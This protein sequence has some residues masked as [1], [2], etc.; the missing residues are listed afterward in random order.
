MGLACVAAI[1]LH[2]LSQSGSSRSAED[3]RAGRAGAV[4]QLH[5]PVPLV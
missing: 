3:A 2:Q 1:F 4:T 5:I